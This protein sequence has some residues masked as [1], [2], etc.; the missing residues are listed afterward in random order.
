MVFF[1]LI[2]LVVVWRAE[3]NAFQ[4]AVGE[5][6]RWSFGSVQ[7]LRHLSIRGCLVCIQPVEHRSLCRGFERICRRMLRYKMLSSSF[8]F[9]FTQFPR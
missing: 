5:Y 4:G 7:D 9:M 2:L 3:Q 8:A 1:V 6:W